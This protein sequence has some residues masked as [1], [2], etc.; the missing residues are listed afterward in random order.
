[1]DGFV[2]ESILLL[3]QEALL[4]RLFPETHIHEK[5][6]QLLGAYREGLLFLTLLGYLT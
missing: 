3:R 4:L 1:M 2:D 5:H 6:V